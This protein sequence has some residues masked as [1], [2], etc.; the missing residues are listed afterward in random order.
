MYEHHYSGPYCP[1]NTSQLYARAPRGV[2]LNISEVCKLL[3][4][5]KDRKRRFSVKDTDEAFLILLE[6]YNI[7]RR[8]VSTTRDHA[9]EFISQPGVFNPDFSY[10]FGR[11]ARE[12]SLPNIC[13]DSLFDPSVRPSLQAPPL[14]QS[15][16]VDV[17][18]LYIL[19]HGQPGSA[20]P[21]SGII[22]DHAL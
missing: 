16:E 3:T 18:G 4:L 10:Y 13:R 6:L 5:I 8:V 2:P 14:S 22:M 9:M 17:Y 15:L 11:G 7:A 1:P 20:T 21:I 19:L 12:P